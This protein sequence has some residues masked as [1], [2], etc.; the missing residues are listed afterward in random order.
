[1]CHSDIISCGSDHSKT[2]E[3]LMIKARLCVVVLRYSVRST[4][5]H[6]T[7]FLCLC[8]G[9]V[10]GTRMQYLVGIK[11]YYKSPSS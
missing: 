2:S 10:P 11:L 6:V 4:Y 9:C 7:L 8:S 3:Q 1:M 5:V